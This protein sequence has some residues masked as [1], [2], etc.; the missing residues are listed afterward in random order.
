MTKFRTFFLKISY[1]E[2]NI[3][4]H[5]VEAFEQVTKMIA[6]T[7]ESFIFLLLGLVSVTLDWSNFSW[8]FTAFALVLCLFF[9]PFWTT[10]F[11][12][13]A[14]TWRTGPLQIS[15][16]DIFMMSLAGLR[17]GIAFALMTSSNIGYF[18]SVKC[19]GKEVLL[20]QI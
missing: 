6:F 15:N 13:I 8:K 5:T 18:D 14:N 4:H 11:A 1:A 2:K 3:A 17:G 20:R 16:T 7:T 10:I 12:K 9:R 19:D